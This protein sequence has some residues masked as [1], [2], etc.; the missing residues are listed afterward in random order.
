MGARPAGR[1]HARRR[2]PRV[3]RFRAARQA[4]DRGAGGHHPRSRLRDTLRRIRPCASADARDPAKASTSCAEA[5]SRCSHRRSSDTSPSTTTSVHRAA[6]PRVYVPTGLRAHRS[7]CP[8][9]YVPTGLRAHRSTRPQ[10]Y[11][12]TGL[13]AH[14]PTCPQVY[15]RAGPR[16]CGCTRQLVCMPTCLRAYV[17]A[18]LRVYAPTR[19]R[20][21]AQRRSVHSLLEARTLRPHQRCLHQRRH[22]L[23]DEARVKRPARQPASPHDPRRGARCAIRDDRQNRRRTSVKRH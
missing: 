10:V 15:M 11:A 19:L 20:S 8:Q 23:H 21:E 6:C 7:T 3:Q 1:P 22:R 17:S 18:R 13:R 14:R 5:S 12:P 16:N 2:V 9:V 4:Q